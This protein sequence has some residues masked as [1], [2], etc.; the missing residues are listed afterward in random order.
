MCTMI[1]TKIQVAGT[2]IGGDA[3]TKVDEA[4]AGY[5][6]ATRLWTEHAVR[7]DLLGGGRTVAAVE[8]DL[9]SARALRALL[10]DVIAQAE[11]S[12]V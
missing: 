12:G 5:D 2:A 4:A 9:G 11:A 1:A 3:W 10:D 7:L 8:L 6:H